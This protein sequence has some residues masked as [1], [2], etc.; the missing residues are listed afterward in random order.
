[1]PCNGMINVIISLAFT[2]SKKPHMA[3]EKCASRLRKNYEIFDPHA[4][5]ALYIYARGL[6]NVAPGGTAPEARH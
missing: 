2:S 1:M 5:F 3:A 6:S 4:A